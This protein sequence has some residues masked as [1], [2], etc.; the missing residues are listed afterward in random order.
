MMKG[1]LMLA[2][3]GLLALGGCGVPEEKA[4]APAGPVEPDP[5]PH[6]VLLVM[7]TARMNRLSA[8]GYDRETTPNLAALKAESRTYQEAYSV[9]NWT[10]PSHASMFTGLYSVAHQATQEDW[11]LRSGLT[12]VAEVLSDE[13]YETI[14]FAGNAMVGR[15]YQF[16]QGF[17]DYYQPWQQKAP[18]ELGFT[19]ET[20]PTL[21]EMISI[22]MTRY[23][24]RRKDP[25]PMFMFVNLIGAHSPYDSCEPFCAEFISDPDQTT[26]D[27]RSREY[28]QGQA[29]FNEAEI[30]HM[31]ESYDAELKKVDQIL[32]RLLHSLEAEGY[33]ENTLLIVT[34]DHG[35]NI[36]DHDGEM[37]HVVTLFDTTCRVPLLVRHPGNPD[38]EAG[39]E[40]RVLAQLPDLF[41]TMLKAAGVDPEP[42]APQGIDLADAETR[43]ARPGLLELYRPRQIFPGLFTGDMPEEVRER[44]RKYDRVLRA[45]IKDGYKYIMGSDGSQWLYHTAADPDETTDLSGDPA[46]AERMAAYRAELE[47]LVAGYGT[48]ATVG[49]DDRAEDVLGDDAKRVLEKLGYL[50]K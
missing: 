10:S 40:D 38:F 28:Y 5:R 4:A 7:D 18:E 8:Y 45:L 50:G 26:V 9:S 6:I 11:T 29:S 49:P 30:R 35:E 37:G 33:K 3:A 48:R 15:H 14:G 1:I 41:P 34:S 21:D 27:N 32:G 31:N 2:A 12:T 39:S 19:E 23:L 20:A 16:D 42:Y 25:R 24:R 17:Q 13:G 22:Q 43:A 46:H 47:E 44:V 36:G